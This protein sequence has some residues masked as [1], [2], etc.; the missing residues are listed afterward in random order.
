MNSG[1][2]C[3]SEDDKSLYEVHVCHVVGE[4]DMIVEIMSVVNILYVEPLPGIDVHLRLCVIKSASHQRINA[5]VGKKTHTGLV[6][7]CIPIYP[8]WTVSTAL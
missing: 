3:Q 4:Y 2:E 1:S 5:V 8:G 6:Q 7:H